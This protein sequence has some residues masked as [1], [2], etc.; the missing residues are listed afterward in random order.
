M[1]SIDIPVSALD[2][3]PALVAQATTVSG[4][5]EY[6]Y[7]LKDCQE[8]ESTGDLF[9]GF[10]V[11]DPASMLE[12][13]LASEK[14]KSKRNVGVG[15]IKTLIVESPSHGKVVVKRD[16]SGRENCWYDPTP[17]YEGKDRVSFLVEL[18]GKS[19]R[20]VIELHVF[21]YVD[22]NNPV[23]RSRATLIKV[24]KPVKGASNSALDSGT[25]GFAKLTGSALGLT[26]GATITLDADAAGYRW[27]IE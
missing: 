17:N 4:S 9:T 11:L 1:F 2:E 7:V 19:Y 14:G 10:R 6:D 22:E 5:V 26:L 21:K 18:D 23:C 25:V 20:V 12:N 13:Y 8:T 3:P 16:G 15:A 27:F 24:K